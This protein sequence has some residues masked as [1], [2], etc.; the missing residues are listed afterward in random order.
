MTRVGQIVGVWGL[1]G[2][3]KVAP[4]VNFPSPFESGRRLRLDDE[5][6]T[7]ED[8]VW[9][10]GRPYLKLSGVDSPEAA[11][12]LQW[13]YLEAQAEDIEL[14]EDEYRTADLIGLRVETEV[15]EALGQV[16]EVL[17]LPAHDVLVVG[18][19]M[20]PAV[21]AFVL[22]VDIAGGVIVVRLIEGMSG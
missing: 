5:W 2:Y 20:I 19:I 10:K 12:A 6:V 8:T 4:L 7:V 9:Q 22:K 11:R 3:V 21:K 16:G 17:H 15:G 14:A 1:K 18:K 13:K